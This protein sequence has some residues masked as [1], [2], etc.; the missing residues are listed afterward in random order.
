MASAVSAQASLSAA[1]AAWDADQNDQSL[2]SSAQGALHNFEDQFN[3]VI[4]AITRM[5][6][7]GIKDL[8]LARIARAVQKALETATTLTF[9]VAALLLTSKS[10]WYVADSCPA[11]S[12]IQPRDSRPPMAELVNTIAGF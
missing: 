7:L 11:I 10:F 6:S 2:Q 1:L 12:K 4:N 9:D 3:Q 5:Q 8:V